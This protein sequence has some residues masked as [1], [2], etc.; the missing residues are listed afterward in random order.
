MSAP[1][2]FFCLMLCIGLIFIVSIFRLLKKQSEEQKQNE[3]ARRKY[4]KKKY[5]E[6]AKRHLHLNNTK[7]KKI[8]KI[9]KNIENKNDAKKEESI[10]FT[11]R[12]DSIE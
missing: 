8:N 1:I 11:T 4:I 5:A 12:L 7:K 3:L 2:L 9:I 6:R 10:V